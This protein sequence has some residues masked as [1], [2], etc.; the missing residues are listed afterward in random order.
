MGRR[1]SPPAPPQL[2]S[3]KLSPIELDKLGELMNLDIEELGSYLQSYPDFLQQQG[4]LGDLEGFSTA[5]NRSTQN[6]LEGVAPGT[7]DNLRRAS[8]MV[9]SQLRGEIPQ[10]VQDQLFSGAAFRNLATGIGQDSGIARNLTA[11]DFGATSA[12]IQQ[13]GLRNYPGVLSIANA[14]APVKP[15]DLLF[16]PA[17]VLARQ[18]ANVAIR[19]VEAE[20]ETNIANY[21]TTYNNDIENQQ[22]YYNTGVK[23]EQ[24][25]MDTNVA[26]TNAMNKYNYDLMKWQMNRGGLFGSGIGGA[27]GTVLGAGIGAIGGP[28]GMLA[29]ASIGNAF[30]GGVGSAFSGGGFG[31]LSSGLLSGLTG[32]SGIGTTPTNPFGVLGN[33]FGRR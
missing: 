22:R 29:G 17:E 30:G 23:N 26:N 8:D 14:L 12:E 24:S 2:Q 13:Q 7:M 6:I 19:N 20:Y 3:P 28:A 10:D 15:S 21:R 32:L 18:D 4:V 27:I 16:S 31:G 33:M 25:I 5:A 11:R 1:S 9:S